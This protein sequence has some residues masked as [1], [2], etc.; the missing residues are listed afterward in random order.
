[1]SHAMSPCRFLRCKITAA[2]SLTAS[3]ISPNLTPSMA[4]R[5]EAVIPL[6]AAG[7]QA[8]PPLKSQLSARMKPVWVAIPRVKYYTGHKAA[9][10]AEPMVDVQDIIASKPVAARPVAHAMPSAKSALV[11]Q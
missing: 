2:H 9:I 1:M 6:P 7:L 11:K 3:S 8:A 10:T 4:L 5:D